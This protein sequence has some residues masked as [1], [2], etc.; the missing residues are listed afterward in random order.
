MLTTVNAAAVIELIN[1]VLRRADDPPAAGT[2]RVHCS[3]TGPAI[4]ADSSGRVG[5]G[6]RGGAA[7]RADAGA[8]AGARRKP[9]CM[10][11]GFTAVV[12]LPQAGQICSTLAAAGTPVAAAA[13]VPLAG[14]DAPHLQQNLF[15]PT[16]AVPH[17]SHFQATLTRGTLDAWPSIASG[18]PQLLQYRTPVVL[19]CPH[20]EHC[21]TFH[22]WHRRST[23]DQPICP[24]LRSRSFLQLQRQSQWRRITVRVPAK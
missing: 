19:S 18:A 1:Q 4:R 9:Q 23:S 2:A 20:L 13:G 3:G 15:R 7:S 8:A 17:A 5:I 21:M 16:L 24:I 10:Q 12:G 6:M 14:Q 11:N 22:H